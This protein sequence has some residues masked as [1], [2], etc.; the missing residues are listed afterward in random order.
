MK[1]KGFSS[2]V[3]KDIDNHSGESLWRKYRDIKAFV[4][5]EI[6]DI[7]ASCMPQCLSQLRL[8]LQLQL[9]PRQKPSFDMQPFLLNL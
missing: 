5:N 1:S 3:T 8:E 4:I 2:I 7:Y 6:S 9:T